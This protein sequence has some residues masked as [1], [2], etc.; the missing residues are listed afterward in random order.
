MDVQLLR[1]MNILA[2]TVQ[3]HRLQ[4]LPRYERVG[5]YKDSGCF[6][7]SV[8][9]PSFRSC[10]GKEFLP[11]GKCGDDLERLGEFTRLVAREKQPNPEMWSAAMIHRQIEKG[12]VPHTWS[13]LL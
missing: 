11:L 13:K 8:C 3:D 1:L 4:I 10:D 12:W 6:V 5:R 2:D 9:R 7:A